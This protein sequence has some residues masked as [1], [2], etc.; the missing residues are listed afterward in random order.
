VNS[1]YEGRGFFH[2]EENITVVMLTLALPF[3]DLEIFSQFLGISDAIF[4][5]RTV[6]SKSTNP[7]VF[8]FS[9]LNR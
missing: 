1:I 3:S 8:A 9:M 4:A 7:I 6:T 5:E 2:A